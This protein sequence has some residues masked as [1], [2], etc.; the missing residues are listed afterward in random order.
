M[1]NVLGPIGE[2]IG[3]FY[4][5]GFSQPMMSQRTNNVAID[6]KQLPHYN[7]FTQTWVQQNHRQIIKKTKQFRLFTRY[8]SFR[9][10]EVP[11]NIIFVSF[12]SA[13]H[14]TSEW[15]HD[16]C[17][18]VTYTLVVGSFTSIR[19]I[20]ILCL[21]TAMRCFVECDLNVHRNAPWRTINENV[22]VLL[23][24]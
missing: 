8:R 13:W 22:C 19:S 10:R 21:Q 23:F 16:F 14:D 20:E 1:H 12:Y 15:S 24:V 4:G 11:R 17:N 5:N 18:W 3:D 6:D 2:A 9:F 7:D